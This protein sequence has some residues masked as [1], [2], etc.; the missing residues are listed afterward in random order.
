MSVRDILD[1][2]G[3]VELREYLVILRRRWMSV[4]I[5]ALTI[6]AVASLVTLLMPKK[7]TATTRLYFSVTAD[8]VTEL[9]QGSAFAEGQ[10]SSYAQVATSPKVLDAV[11]REV[12][13]STTAEELAKSVVVT[14]PPKTVVLKIAA[15]DQDPSRAARIAD[16]I[17]AEL[18]NV[19][20]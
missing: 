13:L 6:L 12:R 15:T 17:G 11:I 9:A 8:S 1:S 4:L 16:A 3:P 5:V 18:A 10:M 14:V 19:A 7:Y 2:G 20:E